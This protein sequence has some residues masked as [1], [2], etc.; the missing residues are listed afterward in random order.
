[1][2]EDEKLLDRIKQS[3]QHD[4][5]VLDRDTA[6]ELAARRFNATTKR[7]S[8]ALPAYLPALAFSLPA[9]A[10]IIVLGVPGPSSFELDS[11]GDIDATALVD[12][13]LELIEE[14]EFYRWLDAHGYA[15]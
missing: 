14:L 5:D 1:M 15:G 6:L 7:E 2:T 4:A 8:R 12:E 11:R 13:D 3:L 10:L 9:M